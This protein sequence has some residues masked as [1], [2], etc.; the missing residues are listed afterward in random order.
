MNN[1]LQKL[2]L[3]AEIQSL[4]KELLE[5][6]ETIKEI[7]TKKIPYVRTRYLSV[8]TEQQIEDI[9][10]KKLRQ[11]ACDL[12]RKEKRIVKEMQNKKQELNLLLIS[13]LT[14]TKGG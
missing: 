1:Y 11:Y 6:K 13:Q 12:R 9:F 4:E 10:V 3:Q 7:E 2:K 8:C 14:V 5:T